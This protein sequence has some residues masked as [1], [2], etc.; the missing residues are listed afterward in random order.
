MVDL[1]DYRTELMQR[2]SRTWAIAKELIKGA[3]ERQNKYYDCHAKDPKIAV[4]DCVMV[5]MPGVRLFDGPYRVLQVTPN[6][7][8]GV[9]VDK[10]RDDTNFVSLNLVHLC[11]QKVA[12]KERQKENSSKHSEEHSSTSS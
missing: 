6:Y 7:A 8:K 1:N 9:L 10:P 12:Q 5:R 2:L 11:Y 3:Q 4:D